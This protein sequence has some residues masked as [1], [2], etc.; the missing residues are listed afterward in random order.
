MTEWINNP[1]VVVA[2]LSVAGLIFAAGQWVGRVN[3]H[4]NGVSALLKEI[5]FDIKKI[6]GRLPPVAVAGDSPLR[7]TDLGKSISRTLDARQWAQQI[8]DTMSDRPCDET[9]Y[10]VQEFCFRYV[11]QDFQ[12][13]RDQNAQLR[14]CA[15]ENGLKLDKVLDV[16]AIELRDELLRKQRRATLRER[17]N[18]TEADISNAVAWARSD[19]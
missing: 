11:K 1:V 19:R 13:D 18:T 8:A 5:R 6:L 17:L 7:L 9:P 4:V 16:L 15:S 10:D 2:V 3:S 14:T 12:P